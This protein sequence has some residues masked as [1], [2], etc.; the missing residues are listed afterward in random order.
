MPSFFVLKVISTCVPGYTNNI[1]C[2]SSTTNSIYSEPMN[3]LNSLNLTM[4]MI[5]RMIQ[6]WM[7][8]WLN[9]YDIYRRISD[10]WWLDMTF[11]NR[12]DTY[13][14][15]WLNRC[16]ANRTERGALLH[17]VGAQLRLSL[18][19]L[20]WCEAQLR[21]IRFFACLASPKLLNKKLELSQKINCQKTYIQGPTTPSRP[22]RWW[23]ALSNNALARFSPSTKVECPLGPKPKSN[24][25]VYITI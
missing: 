14:K 19:L 13:E 10:P 17:C 25:I 23:H 24:L 9:S 21:L 18:A 22:V 11:V 20:R 1:V 6:N 2:C 8:K 5:E 7:L 15:V 3:A 16:E 12:M 4:N